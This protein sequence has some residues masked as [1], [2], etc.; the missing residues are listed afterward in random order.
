M[1][2]AWRKERSHYRIEGAF[3]GEAAV[4]L[5]LNDEESCGV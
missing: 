1:L 5:K 4:E 3:Y 2:S